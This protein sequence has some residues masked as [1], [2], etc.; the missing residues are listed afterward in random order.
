MADP[1]L[2]AQGRQ[3]LGL[4][5]ERDAESLPVPTCDCGAQLG[6]T[7]V[8][9]IAVVVRIRRCLL[10]HVDDPAWRWQVGIADAQRDDVHPGA[11]LLLH[12]A[13]DLREEIG[14]N[15][16]Q[17]LRARPFRVNRLAHPA[18]CTYLRIA[19]SGS[20]SISNHLTSGSRR[21]QRSCRRA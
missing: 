5:V 8:R 12:L 19:G 21:H 10:E 15:S 20:G 14:R 7:E 11:L 3:D 18:C 6:Q 16:A 4:R 13:V 17:P 2:G 9:R 1:V